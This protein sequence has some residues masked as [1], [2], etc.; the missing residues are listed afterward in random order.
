MCGI[1]AITSN[2]DKNIIPKLFTSLYR[3]EYRGYDSA[4]I[5]YI[6]TDGKIKIVKTAGKIDK[7]EKKAWPLKS[8]IKTGVGHTRWAT[9]GPPTDNNAHPHMDCNAEIALVHNG[10]IKNFYE[11]RVYLEKRG[12]KIKSDTDTEL[13]AH[14]LEENLRETNGDMLKALGRTLRQIEGSYAFAILYINDPKRVYFAKNES[15]LIIGL[16][17]DENYLA[18][19]I[20]AF[21]EYTRKIIVLE[22]G[23][24]GWIE[25]DRV[26]IESMTGKSI[27]IR[28]RIRVVEWSAER[29]SKAGYQH[30]MLKEIHEQP[31][32]LKETLIGITSAREALKAAYIIS[33]ADRIFI[34]AAGTSYHAALYFDYIMN[35]VNGQAII[36]FVASEYNK[37]LNSVKDNDVLIAVSQ[38]GET[39]DTLRAVKEFKKRGA[40]VIAVSNIIGSAIPRESNFTVYTRAGPEIGVAATKTFLAQILALE[41]IA[42]EYGR[43]TLGDN[44]ELKQ[45]W[46]ALEKAPQI[47]EQ[48]ILMTEGL[49]KELAK[50]IIKN[51]TN[52]YYLGRGTGYP[53]ALEG[54]LKLKEIAYIHAEA[55]PAGESK[56]GP[57][58]LVQRDFPTLFIITSDSRDAIIGN[59]QEMRAR[60]ALII[61]VTS[62]DKEIED[63][64][65]IAIVVPRAEF[66]LLEPYSIMPPL[67]LLA[68]YTAITL[69]YNP[70]KPRNLAKTV[71][72]E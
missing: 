21:L 31:R 30:F 20:P 14:L 29:A 11:L 18:S 1:I 24:Y 12:H 15:P 52:M 53:L 68:Y 51:K 28:D 54:A 19:D 13:V 37:Y 7:L 35:T 44:K 3:L 55:Y 48:S 42:L 34:T 59:I 65:D 41:Y 16:G 49:V 60:N 61:T 72:V 25:P 57:I 5:A 58:A 66:L 64:A 47:A 26:H 62:K 67:Q 40:R 10:I 70:D 63:Q 43:I 38:S 69:G 71:T 45:L 50:T 36:P 6:D 17:E 27:N 32:A 23:E 2:K 56:H 8:I 4:G 33:N 46:S 22:D 39:I 9:H